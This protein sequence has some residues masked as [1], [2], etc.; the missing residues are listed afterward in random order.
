[1]PV[2]ADLSTNAS[3]R[4]ICVDED[5]TG[6]AYLANLYIPIFSLDKGHIIHRYEVANQIVGLQ[7]NSNK[8]NTVIAID[9]SF[10][11]HIFDLR[12]NRKNKKRLNPE[13]ENHNV[14]CIALSGTMLALSSSEFAGG[15]YDVRG[16]RR[17]EKKNPNVV[18]LFDIRNPNEPITTYGKCHQ[19]EITS[20]EF[21]KNGNDLLTGSRD[22]AIKVFDTQLRDESNALRW[23]RWAKG[24]ITKVGVINKR[25]VYGIS[26]R[27]EVNVFV[28][29]REKLEV[30]YGSVSESAEDRVSR[31][32]KAFFK[33]PEWCIGLIKGMNDV[34]PLVAVHGVENEK[35]LALTGM[36]QKGIRQEKPL[37]SYPGHTGEVK[38]MAVTPKL[39]LTGGE[40]GKVV[41]QYSDYKNKQFG[42]DSIHHHRLTLNRGNI[43][44]MH[45][46][47]E[48]LEEEKQESSDSSSESDDSVSDVE[49]KEKPNVSNKTSSSSKQSSS[50]SKS[51]AP[52]EPAVQADTASSSAT[53]S[54]SSGKGKHLSARAKKRL[55]NKELEKKTRKHEEKT[56]YRMVMDKEYRKKMLVT[57]EDRRK[58]SDLKRE[59]M[60]KY[61]SSEISKRINRTSDDEGWETVNED[62]EKEET[63]E[64]KKIAKTEKSPEKRKNEDSKSSTPK[65]ESSEKRKN[66]DSKSF[67]PKKESSS[68]KESKEESDA[69]KETGDVKTE[70]L[71]M[72]GDDLKMTKED[73]REKRRSMKLSETK[74]ER[75][76]RKERER[77]ERKKKHVEDGSSSSSEAKKS[78]YD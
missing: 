34:H 67:T 6:C 1:M 21:Y 28:D 65:K 20:M 49:K 30:L 19:A 10:G 64:E 58:Y 25:I 35:F 70:K 16:S 62:D 52:S 24:P 50:S 63:S 45:D 8:K 36:D 18:T 17:R 48:D 72:Q 73:E 77:E 9:D 13:V 68:K 60:K 40:D 51:A 39:L 78:K 47:G 5:N 3:V 37:L 75:A 69:Q 26:D 53:P 71:S 74:E 11:M 57:T 38:C 66:E 2:L 15:I 4:L 22:G 42:H 76:A 54:S 44:E 41:I 46:K 31:T 59:Y 14:N 33:K 29:T 7:M 61:S 55:A 23:E 27:S 12:S 32:S 43:A 56:K